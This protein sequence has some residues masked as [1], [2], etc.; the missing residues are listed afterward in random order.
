MQS[1]PSLSFKVDRQQRRRSAV[2]APIAADGRRAQL[3]RG[4]IWGYIFG[5]KPI[6][7]IINRLR[8]DVSPSLHQEPVLRLPR[9]S[10]IQGINPTKSTILGPIPSNAAVWKPRIFGAI[11]GVLATSV[12]WYFQK[13]GSTGKARPFHGRTNGPV[14]TDPKVKLSYPPKRDK[15][16][17]VWPLSYPN[18]P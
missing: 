9:P 6:R 7:R 8:G 10:R 16:L 2:G 11:S 18:K 4:Y 13:T 3:G 14:A 12:W 15:G 17:T 1:H 5:V